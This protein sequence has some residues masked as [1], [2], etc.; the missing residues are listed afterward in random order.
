MEIVPVAKRDVHQSGEATQANRGLRGL[1]AKCI[2]HSHVRQEAFDTPT[3]VCNLGTVI[4]VLDL[5]VH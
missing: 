2:F 1:C 5:D 4:R 3:S